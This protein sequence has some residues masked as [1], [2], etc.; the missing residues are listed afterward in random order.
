MTS[1]AVTF[2][3]RG[4]ECRAVVASDGAVDDLEVRV[5]DDEPWEAADGHTDLLPHELREI[6]I[7]AMSEAGVR[8]HGYDGIPAGQ[9]GLK[10]GWM[11]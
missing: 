1:R 8:S 3:C 10:E 9:T 6:E 5:C 4:W 7:R 2:F 11:R